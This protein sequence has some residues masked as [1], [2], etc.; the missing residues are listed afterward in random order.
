MKSLAMSFW[1]LLLLALA[2]CGPPP[3]LATPTPA[4]EPTTEVTEPTEP[5]DSEPSEPVAPSEPEISLNPAQVN[6]FEI[7]LLESFPVQVH[8]AIDG[9]LSGSCSTLEEIQ[10]VQE[11]QTFT[12]NVVQAT[13]LNVP[14]TMA[15]V[16]FTEHV[17]LDVVG[18]PAGEYTVVVHDLPPQTF[19]LDADNSFMLPEETVASEAYVTAVTITTVDENSGRATL[20]IEGELAN[21]CTVIDEI[22]LTNFVD[23]QFTVQIFTSQPADLVCTQATVPFVQNLALD[24][25]SVLP[26]GDYQIDVQG[27]V[28]EFSLG[29]GNNSL[30]LPTLPEPETE[31]ETEIEKETEPITL[32]PA[33]VLAPVSTVRVELD[34]A[35]TVASVFITGELPDGCEGVAPTGIMLVAPYELQM[36]LVRTVPA[37]V[38]C[39]EVITPYELLVTVDVSGLPAGTYDLAVNEATAVFTLR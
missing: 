6:Q 20:Q 18:L 23:N 27:T 17:P 22:R 10:T 16:P 35:Q 32:E 21:G 38:M 2:A 26:P 3:N 7:L 5:T 25:L 15:L 1:L 24:S 9:M 30:L 39:P 33:F 11:G 31:P 14:C 28:A 36:E 19:T 34:A 29:K 4:A 8:V 12:L 13:T 37:D